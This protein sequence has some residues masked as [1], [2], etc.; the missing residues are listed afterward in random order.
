MRPTK[1]N[2]LIR[3]NIPIFHWDKMES[4]TDLTD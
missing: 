2:K 4:K 3:M 1:V